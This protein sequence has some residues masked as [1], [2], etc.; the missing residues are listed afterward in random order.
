[1]QIIALEYHDVVSPGRWDE[2]GF[3]GI[4]AATYKLPVDLFDAHLGALERAGCTLVNDISAHT[5]NRSASPPVVLTFDDGGSGYFAHAADLLEARGW[6]GHLFMTTGWIGKPGFLSAAD[7][8]ELARR[9]H[10][11]G[12]H[13]RNHPLR[14]AAL[15]NAEI[16]GEWDSSLADLQGVLG[17]AVRVASVPGGYHSRRVAELAA[18]HGITTL[19]TS[20]P[21]MSIR[22]VDG[23]TVI[24]R[25][26]LRRS[27]AAAY[28]GRLVGRAPVARAIQWCQ[29]NAKKVAKALGGRHYLRVRDRVF[30]SGPR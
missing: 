24:G 18:E 4:S 12:S 7:L 10:V 27:H 8:R 13:S 21:E 23:C 5:S 6:R 22:T 2:S 26:T 17:S 1:M 16:A 29:W 11:I 25:Y 19:F 9:G 28:A 3:P 14:M 30:E 15:S 20:E